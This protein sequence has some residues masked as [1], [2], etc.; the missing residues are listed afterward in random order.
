MLRLFFV[1]L[2]LLC[3]LLHYVQCDVIIVDSNEVIQNFDKDT[4]L[5]LSDKVFNIFLDTTTKNADIT[6]TYSNIY[7]KSKVTINGTCAYVKD[8]IKGRNLKYLDEQDTLE[9]IT[10]PSTNNFSIYVY[11][12]N[13]QADIIPLIYQKHP[14]YISY[15]VTCQETDIF[16][17]P[18]D[19]KQNKNVF[20]TSPSILSQLIVIFLIFFFLFIGFSVLMNI[21]T[22]KIFEDKQL[23]INKEH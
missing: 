22:P 18:E 21:S 23:I 7:N 10:T 14:K 1:L 6:S 4:V 3:F 9:Y 5:N 13:G 20:H 15:I 11:T 17:N 19:A 8:L 12:I 2:S 16:D